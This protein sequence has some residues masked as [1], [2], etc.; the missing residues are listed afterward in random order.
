ML[1]NPLGPGQA[2]EGRMGLLGL[3]GGM[4]GVAIRTSVKVD[5][6]AAPLVW[7]QIVGSRVELADIRAVSSAFV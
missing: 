5:L 7:K 2:T 1:L 3:V 4:L 6:P